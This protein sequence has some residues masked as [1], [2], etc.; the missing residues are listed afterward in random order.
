MSSAAPLIILLVVVGGIVT[1]GFMTDWTFSG[2][3][4]RAG[5]KCKPETPAT[6]AKQY[7]YSNTDP[8]ACT[9]IATCNTDWLPAKS[10]TVCEYSK[11]ASTCT[12]GGTP[13]PQGVYTFDK[14]KMCILTG[15]K[16]DFKFISASAGCKSCKA[17]YKKDGTVC[18]ACTASDVTLPS[19]VTLNQIEKVDGQT[20]K[21]EG[22]KCIPNRQVFE[23]NI[24]TT[25]CDVYCSGNDTAGGDS[26]VA[27]F[28][29][30]KGAKCVGTAKKDG[31]K[32][33]GSDVCNKLKSWK[34][35]AT[36]DNHCLCERNDSVP[37]YGNVFTMPTTFKSHQKGGAW[38][39]LA[40][41]YG[42]ELEGARTLIE[43][44][45]IARYKGYPAFGV[46]TGPNTCWGYKAGWTKT[47]GVDPNGPATTHY[48][49]CVDPTKKVND[50][51]K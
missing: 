3:L 22:G 2:L 32:L 43:C 33:K 37:W 5:A 17:G 31:T 13:D 1:W 15:C 10:N 26:W 24:G 18:K 30:W 19:G 9:V 8:P 48:T 50:S 23:G 16:N 34:A 47:T 46:R 49:E 25:S 41:G 4:P 20:Y 28:D 27:T 14:S 35:S 40:G 7:V 29:E 38:G 42:D 39:H 45:D 12:P 36:E 11:S 44:R 6:N 21:T 51:C